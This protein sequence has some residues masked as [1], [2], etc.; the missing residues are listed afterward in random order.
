MTHSRD[1]PLPTPNAVQ[2][3][4]RRALAAIRTTSGRD[5]NKRDTLTRMNTFQVLMRPSDSDFKAERLR[6]SGGRVSH[7]VRFDGMVWGLRGEIG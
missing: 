2:E 4:Q 1:A 5:N 3:R 7:R 6:V